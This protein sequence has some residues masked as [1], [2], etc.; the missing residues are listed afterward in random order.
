VREAKAAGAKVLAIT[1]TVGSTL[2]RE[3]DYVLHTHCGPEIGVASTKAFLGQLAAIYLLAGH[4]AAARGRLSGSDARGYAEELLKIPRLIE[5]TLEKEK[6]IAKVADA[7]ASS[8]HFLFISRHINY[9]IA[10]EGALKI[11]EISYVHAEGYPAGEMKHGPIAII[12]K[13][14]PLLAVAPSGRTL[15]LMAGNIEEAKARGADVVA[16]VDAASQKTVK[17]SRYI[18]LPETG[19]LFTPM[20]TVIPLQIFAY[21]VALAKKCD[22]DKP[23][24]LA[25]SVTVR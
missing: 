5:E 24:N 8:E 12:Y 9:P 21:Y 2:T 25:K 17:A 19:E 15:D 23:R 6:E 18:V 20:L 3:A 10:L 1:N 14:M 22:I 4:F 16:I 11:K 7:F 13:G